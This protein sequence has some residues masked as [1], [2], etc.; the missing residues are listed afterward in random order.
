[1][2]YIGGHKVHPKATNLKIYFYK[3]RIQIGNPKL[4][5]PYSAIISI[6]KLDE[7]KIFAGRVIGWDRNKINRDMKA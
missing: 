2:K 5:I 4:I 1:M 6:E 3:D 7:Q